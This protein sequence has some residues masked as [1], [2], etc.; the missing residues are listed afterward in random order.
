MRAHIHTR[1]QSS[2]SNWSVKIFFYLSNTVITIIIFVLFFYYFT[3]SHFDKYLNFR[4]RLH[5]AIGAGS[6]YCL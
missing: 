6:G 4:D 5:Y 2:T 3:L 1:T